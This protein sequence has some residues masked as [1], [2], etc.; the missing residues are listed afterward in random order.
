MKSL[1]KRVGGFLMTLS[2]V[3]S[4]FGFPMAVTPVDNAINLNFY[5]LFGWQALLAYV[6]GLAAL[7]SLV[8]M[9]VNCLLKEEEPARVSGVH[10]G[11]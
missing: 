1:M 6:G 8:L 3:A 4:A 2:L 9:A 10:D 7:V 5:L 11:P